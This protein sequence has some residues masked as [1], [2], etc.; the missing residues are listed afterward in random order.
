[1]KDA[2]SL[3]EIIGEERQALGELY[4]NDI[5]VGDNKYLRHCFLVAQHIAFEKNYIGIC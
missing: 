2:F 4:Q 5:H 1:M 3:D